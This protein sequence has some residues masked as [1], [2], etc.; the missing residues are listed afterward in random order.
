M[1]DIYHYYPPDTDTR[2]ACGRRGDKRKRDGCK[3]GGLIAYF[4]RH[5]RL[6]LR[7]KTCQKQF[8]KDQ[9]KA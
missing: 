8:E 7:C 1:K 4:F 3:I 5:V 9:K 2:T 6:D